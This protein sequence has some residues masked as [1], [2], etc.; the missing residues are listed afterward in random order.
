[1]P[2]RGGSV[3]IGK[4]VYAILSAAPRMADFAPFIIP[5]IDAELK[6]REQDGLIEGEVRSSML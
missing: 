3:E 5:E 1:M 2:A 6:K 4:P